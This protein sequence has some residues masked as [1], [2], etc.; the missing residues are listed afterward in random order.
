M[1]HHDMKFSRFFPT[2][3]SFLR[4]LD[5]NQRLKDELMSSTPTGIMLKLLGEGIAQRSKPLDEL[6]GS[7]VGQGSEEGLKESGRGDGPGAGTGVSIGRKARLPEVMKGPARRI[8]ANTPGEQ[9][10]PVVGENEVSSWA[11]SAAQAASLIGVSVRH[12]WRLD[13][14][15]KIPAAI[16]IGKKAKKWRSEE[17]KDWLAAGCPP[18]REWMAIR[19]RASARKNQ[20][21]KR[22]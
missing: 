10:L 9:E 21:R 6:L 12:W 18:R 14:A 1:T 2:T 13:S 19:E 17:L 8:P 16:T 3:S 5:G 20:S 15:G 4:R 11:V 22:E 7:P